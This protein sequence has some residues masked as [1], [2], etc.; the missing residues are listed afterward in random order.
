MKPSPRS[1]SGGFSL[2]EVAL[3]LAILAVG[4]TGV[5]A[6]LPVGLDSAR[7]VHAETI[8][9]QIVRG[10]VADFATN[11]YAQ[12]DFDPLRQ[13]AP[14]ST[15]Q[16]SYYTQE[17]A[18]TKNPPVQAEDIPYFRL[19]YVCGYVSERRCRYFLQM[20]W[21]AAADPKAPLAQRRT[22]FAD[23]VRNY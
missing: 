2:V 4:M 20:S 11:G 5:L 19:E 9:A 10:A 15:L 22:F 21:P 17:G 1:G 12:K 14:G 23:V 6:L 7:Q 13:K 3:S 8:A 16:T 18:P